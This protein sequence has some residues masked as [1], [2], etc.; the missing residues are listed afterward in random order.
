MS[1]APHILNTALR[2]TQVDTRDMENLLVQ[3][4]I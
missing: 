2:D 4:R 1:K 3:E